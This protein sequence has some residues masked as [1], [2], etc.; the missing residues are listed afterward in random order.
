MRHGPLDSHIRLAPPQT[1]GS[2]QTLRHGFNDSRGRTRAGQLDLGLLFACFQND[3]D[4]G[5]IA[6][7]RRLDGKPLEEYIEP[8]GGGFY[9]LP[10]VPDATGDIGQSMVEAVA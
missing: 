9:V 8:F 10:G 6:I 4:E 1:P 7:Q 3:L 2:R 5:V